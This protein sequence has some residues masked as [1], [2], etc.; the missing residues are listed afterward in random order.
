MQVTDP[1]C[2]MQVDSTKAAAT[3]KYQGQTFYFCSAGCRE[4][5]RKEPGR[6][7]SAASPGKGPHS[8]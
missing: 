4:K 6:Y 8:G 3:E 7:T 1:V 2:G 5:F